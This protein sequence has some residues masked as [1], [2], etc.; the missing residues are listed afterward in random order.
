MSLLNEMLDEQQKL[1]NRGN[2]PENIS[3]AAQMAQG[4]IL[5]EIQGELARMNEMLSNIEM[6]TRGTD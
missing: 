2:A 6:N 3:T 4:V 1:C 5:A